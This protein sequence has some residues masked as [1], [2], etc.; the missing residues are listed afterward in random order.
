MCAQSLPAN[1][2]NAKN[3]TYATE[4]MACHLDTWSATR[5]SLQCLAQ[6][7]LATYDINSKSSTKPWF[8]NL[9][10]WSLRARVERK[11]TGGQTRGQWYFDSKNIFLQLV[12]LLMALSPRVWRNWKS[13]YEFSF[14]HNQAIM[15]CCSL[16]KI[17]L[18]ITIQEQ[19]FF[20]RCPLSF[21]RMQA[22]LSLGKMLQLWPARSQE[23][24]WKSCYRYK[25]MPHKPNILQ[26][27]QTN[28]FFW[29]IF[30]SCSCCQAKEIVNCPS[31]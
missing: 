8:L 28:R 24:I 17:K 10:L 13:F 16:V 29:C 19:Y 4:Y 18:I 31:G 15:Q 23:G 25:Q 6:G 3:C 11:F 1:Y 26:H 27:E 12:F 2:I 9:W 30:N 7:T 22:S 21:H 14:Q 5:F 20:M